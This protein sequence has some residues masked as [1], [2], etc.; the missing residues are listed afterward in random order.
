MNIKCIRMTSLKPFDWFKDTPFTHNDMM[1]NPSKFQFM[2]TGD[3][4]AIL[5]LRGVTIEQDNHVKLLGVNIDKKNDFK[6]HVNEVIRKYARQL[7]ALRRQ[8]RVLNVLAK[9]KVFNGFIRANLNYC[10]LVWIN[11]NKTD[12]AKLEKVQERAVQ[13]ILND[14]MSTYIDLHR[15]AGVPSVLIRWQRILATNVYKALHGLSLII[16]TKPL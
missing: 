5:K 10:P 8:S 3:S 1:A 15:R 2:T 14:K 9:K 12:V 4:N 11:R 16:Y 7:N 13:L 6:F